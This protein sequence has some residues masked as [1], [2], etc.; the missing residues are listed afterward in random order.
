MRPPRGH[1][2]T[3]A[4]RYRRASEKLAR[5]LRDRVYSGQVMKELEQKYVSEQK[6]L[7][8]TDTYSLHTRQAVQKSACAHSSRSQRRRP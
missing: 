5:D 6:A 7:S 8:E 4:A 1:A 2:G 3:P